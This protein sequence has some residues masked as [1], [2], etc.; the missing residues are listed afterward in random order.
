[1]FKKIKNFLRFYRLIRHTS[2]EI[3]RLEDIIINTTNPSLRSKTY[4]K[5]VGVRSYYF[6]LS[7]RRWSSIHPV[8]R[9]LN[10]EAEHNTNKKT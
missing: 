7:G 5:L 2:T 10:F 8:L 1:M 6:K 3:I 4:K 9:A